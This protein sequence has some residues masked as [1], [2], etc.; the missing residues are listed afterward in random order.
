MKVISAVTLPS[1]AR[2]MGLKLPFVVAV[3]VI[4]PFCALM[5][6]PF[7]SP[8]AENVMSSPSASVAEI[9]SVMLS[10]TLF[11]F[12]GQESTI[13]GA[14]LVGA[15]GLKGERYC[16]A[17]TARLWPG[18]CQATAK[19]S[20]PPPSFLERFDVV[21]LTRLQV[22]Q[23]RLLRRIFCPFAWTGPNRDGGNLCGACRI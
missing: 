10:P 15:F 19:L 2:M 7:G 17:I 5:L 18:I 9:C 23:C 11:W 22:D 6:S 16:P 3:P 13:T 1:L 20:R 4:R 14:S 8:V 21:A 12:L